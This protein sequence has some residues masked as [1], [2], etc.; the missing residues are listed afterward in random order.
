MWIKETKI[1]KALA[2]Y[3]ASIIYRRKI[4]HSI[5][6]L[7]DIETFASGTIIHENTV[8]IVET[9]TFHAETLPGYV[10]Y[11]KELGYNVD[12]FLTFENAVERPFA[13]M[14]YEFR[15]FVGSNMEIQKWIQREKMN[16]YKLIFFSTQF[17][18]NIIYL[19]STLPVTCH[20]KVIAIDHAIEKSAIW[21]RDESLF[22]QMRNNGLTA[23]LSQTEG[24]NRINPHYFGDI[25]ITPKNLEKTVFVTVGS[26]KPCFKN[27]SLL[28][29][30]VGHLV[31]SGIQDFTVYI[32]GSGDI[33][34]PQ[35]LKEYIQK[36]GR[37]DFPTMYSEIEK[38]DYI[39]ALLDPLVEAHHS[40]LKGMT[41]GTV[42]LALGFRKPILINEEF[43]KVYNLS[44]NDSIIYSSDYLS[45]A[46]KQAIQL[47]NHEYGCLQDGLKSSSDSICRESLESIKRMTCNLPVSQ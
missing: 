38:A 21:A 30:A 33:D 9:N 18:N 24:Y 28:I 3:K 46:M 10:H 35:N 14:H 32:I 25:A 34:I 16:Q 6:K 29:D 37:L 12:V 45:S 7:G 1:Y 26:I 5:E 8:A 13:R 2:E 17:F 4:A 40:Y 36:L 47:S 44:Q 11:F 41:S 20:N 23:T 27:H 43:A 39:L 19:P 42:Q 15:V 31:N 22:W